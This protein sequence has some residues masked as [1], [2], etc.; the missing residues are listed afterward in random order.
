MPDEGGR[1]VLVLEEND[2]QLTS[3]SIVADAFVPLA[4]ER[5]DRPDETYLVITCMDSWHACPI[6]IDGRPYFDL[7]DAVSLWWIDRNALT[8]LT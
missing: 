4:K 3:P 5:D 2:I 8:S 7:P 6:L 1:V